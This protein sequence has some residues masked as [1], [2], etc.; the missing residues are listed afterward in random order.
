M[1]TIFC[2]KLHVLILEMTYAESILINYAVYERDA[3][4]SISEKEIKKI[5]QALF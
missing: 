2:A 3:L 5:T 4:L 1:H